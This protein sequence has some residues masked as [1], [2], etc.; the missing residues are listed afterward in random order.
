MLKVTLKF[1]IIAMTSERRFFFF[2]FFCNSPFLDTFFCLVIST[3]KL[4]VQ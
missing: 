2:F 4:F 3:G 1:L